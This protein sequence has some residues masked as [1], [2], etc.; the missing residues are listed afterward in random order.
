MTYSKAPYT[1]L[2]LL[3]IIENRGRIAGVP[4]E[5]DRAFLIECVNEHHTTICTERP[6]KWRKFDRSFIMDLPITTGTVAVT[7]DSRE[8][9]FTGLT[10]SSA[11]LGRSIKIDGAQDMYRIIGV[12]TS[13]NSVYLD[14]AYT[15]ATNATAT[16]RMF[17]Y[18]FP[19]PPDLDTIHQLYIDQP[20]LGHQFPDLDATNVLEFN[21]LLA[22]Y[23]DLA[24][25]PEVYCEDGTVTGENMPPMDILIQDYDFM[26]GEENTEIGRLRVFPIQPDRKR[27]IHLNYSKS[28][29]VLAELTS[30]PMIPFDNRYVL[31]H[32]VLGDWWRRT[33]NHQAGDREDRIAMKLLKEMRAEHQKSEAQPKLIPNGARLRRVHST[34]NPHD[35]LHYISRIAETGGV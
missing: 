12:N 29:E 23:P 10:I 5:R 32:R 8:M 20:I 21:R 16:Y 4:Q 30:V 27:V 33:G 1:L 2:D 28:V 22:A 17:L 19:L 7:V 24:G 11:H 3:Q 15:G 14:V 34:R 13:T 18:E 6:W 31:V 35:E 26:A 9:T 25:P